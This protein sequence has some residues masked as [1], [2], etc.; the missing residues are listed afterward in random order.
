MTRGVIA[1]R[2]RPEAT[3]YLGEE[4]FRA[5]EEYRSTLS[6]PPS[7]SALVRE[8]LRRFLEDARENEET[9]PPRAWVRAT[10]PVMARLA[11]NGIAVNTEEILR[12][13]AKAEEDRARRVLGIEP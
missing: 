1:V 7:A 9:L 8:A 6:V 2:R 12:S 10:E 3:V 11:A 13:I 4:L 5:L